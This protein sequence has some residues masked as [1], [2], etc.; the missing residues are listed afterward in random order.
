MPLEHRAHEAG[1]GPK[2]ALAHAAFGDPVT[3]IMV[4]NAPGVS[5][6]IRP[7]GVYSTAAHMPDGLTNP[8]P[9]QRKTKQLCAFPDKPC[10]AYATTTGYCVFHNQT[11]R[12]RGEL[13]EG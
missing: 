7:A 9:K 5:D 10:R 4:A 6:H 8:P 1:H 11:M 13:V 12:V 3:G 2:V